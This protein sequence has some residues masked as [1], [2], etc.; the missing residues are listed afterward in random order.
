M[1]FI[2]NLLLTAG[3]LFIVFFAPSCRT[4]KEVVYF[5]VPS[6]TASKSNAEGKDSLKTDSLV[7]QDYTPIIRHNDVLE[8]F[9]SSINPE[10]TS[11][12]N[13]L[14][15]FGTG[16]T[17]ILRD[18]PEVLGYLVDANG[19][20]EMPIIGTVKVAGLTIPQIK[21]LLKEK[22]EKYLE[23]PSVRVVL[24]NFKVSILGEVKVPGIYSV[25]NE[26]LSLPEAIAMAG[27]L[28]IFGKRENILIVREENGKKEFANVDMT[29]R[30]FFQ[31]SYYFL[32]PNDVVYVEPVKAKVESSDNFFRWY[33]LTLGTISFLMT[34]TLFVTRNR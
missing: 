33:G 6:D 3:V 2:R 25:I 12:F 1:N 28:T 31:S 34:L 7:I 30:N 15:G 19:E 13:P 21:I 20:I 8:I 17:N 14:S 9:V 10:A 29:Q 11:Y 18:N 26:R 27:D 24:K 22:L 4:L 32:H 5:Q 23:K 16:T